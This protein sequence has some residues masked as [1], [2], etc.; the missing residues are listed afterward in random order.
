MLPQ[1]SNTSCVGHMTL[2]FV[3]N[4]TT[5][6]STNTSTAYRIHFTALHTTLNLQLIING[7]L[8][9]ASKGMRK[10]LANKCHIFLCIN[11]HNTTTK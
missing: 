9:F 3:L 6:S 2:S 11:S 4:K 5:F 10:T 1:V 8:T 7:L